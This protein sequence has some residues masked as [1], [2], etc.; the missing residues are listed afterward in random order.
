MLIREAKMRLEQILD[1]SRAGAADH[2]ALSAGTVFEAFQR[3]ACIPASDAGPVEHDGDGVLAQFGVF[4]LRGPQEF[5]VDLTRQFIEA[6]DDDA[7]M[8]QLACTFYWN[9]TSETEALGSGH[10]WSFGMSLDQFFA[11]AARL[12]GWAWA[13]EASEPPTDLEI[14]LDMV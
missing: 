4:S 3:F 7:P 12:P 8:W 10:L 1:E 9:A 11:A 6:G 13:L 5:N 14:T 2:G